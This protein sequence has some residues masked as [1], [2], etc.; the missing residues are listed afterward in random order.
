MIYADGLE[1]ELWNR[2]V[3]VEGSEVVVEEEEEEDETMV[4]AIMGKRQKF[5]CSIFLS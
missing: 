5:W 3:V 1:S 4:V 2:L